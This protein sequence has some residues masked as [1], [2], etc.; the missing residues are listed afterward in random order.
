M[1]I[2]IK[3]TQLLDG[4]G[5]SAIKADVLIKNDKISAIGNF[6]NYKAD[7]IIDAMGA[8]LAPGFIDINNESDHSLEI[9][10]NDYQENIL[11]QGITSVIGGHGGFSLAPLLY[12]SLEAIKP[13]ADIRKI[14]VDW[15]TLTEF[16]KTFKTRKLNVNFGTFL[17]HTTVR[18]D[19][20][21]DA[22]KLIF[23]DLTPN[24]SAV[25]NFV[26]GKNLKAGA[27]G[28]S[29]GFDHSLASE[30][31]YFEIKKMAELAV[32]VGALLSY[33]LKDNKEGIVD[34]VKKA[35]F[36]A[37]E[38]GVKI[39]INNFKPS[40]EAFN[41]IEEN[42]S[43][44]DICFCA[45]LDDNYSGESVKMLQ[46]D[47]AL[48]S[49]GLPAQAGGFG[50]FLELVE[51]DKI[52]TIEEAVKKIT[53]LPAA[54]LKLDKRGIVREGYFA[55]LVLFR[56]ENSEISDVIINGKRAVKEGKFQ[57]ILEGKALVND[58]F[59]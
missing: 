57:N 47:K 6:P 49:S 41:L 35:I 27:F 38:T 37:K 30:V 24:E 18:F 22:H 11:K 40:L 48:I 51:K 26:M 28:I 8:Y 52:M 56:I 55:D 20:I 3:N 15:H 23:R 25:L 36:L 43:N 59:I 34:S 33:N 54:K 29:V 31:S 39:L 14:N 2:L 13:W 46:S 12:G 1:T 58:K 21:H 16:L 50:K 45:N 9:F 44:A 7:E 19:I 42:S 4:T 10:S 17:G 32:K 53:S 5:R